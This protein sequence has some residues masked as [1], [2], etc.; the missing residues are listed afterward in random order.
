MARGNIDCAGGGDRP[1]ELELVRGIAEYGMDGSG[2]GFAPP[3]P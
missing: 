3:S 1:F 2:S